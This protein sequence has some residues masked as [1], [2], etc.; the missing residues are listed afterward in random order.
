MKGSD[1]LISYQLE[2]KFIAVR[3]RVNFA[4]AFQFS[5]HDRGLRA[6]ALDT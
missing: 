2:Y 4:V 5:L 1:R 6:K 3:S